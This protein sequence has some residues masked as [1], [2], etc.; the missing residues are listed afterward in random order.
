MK[1][2]NTTPRIEPGPL[3]AVIDGS[4]IYKVL[5]RDESEFVL[6]TLDGDADE[7]TMSRTE[8]DHGVRDGKLL[9]EE[10]YFTPSGSIAGRKSRFRVLGEYRNQIQ[11]QVLCDLRWA[12]K[13]KQSRDKTGSPSLSHNALTLWIE[14]EYPAMLVELRPILAS[15][16]TDG[17]AVSSAE[18]AKRTKKRK[19]RR[20]TTIDAPGATALRDALRKLEA[21]NWDVMVLVPGWEN[22]TEGGPRIDPEIRNAL[23][24]I[25]EGYKTEMKPSYSGLRRK[26]RGKLDV[27]NA[28]RQVPL[29]LPCLQTVI[30]VVR[31]TMP[32]VEAL[33]GRENIAAARQKLAMVGE[34]PKY[35][36][37]G[38]HVMMDCWQ[39]HLMSIYKECGRWSL[40]GPEEKD[41]IKPLR[42]WVAVL[43]DSA[44]GCIPGISFSISEKTDAVLGAF[45]MALMD[46]SGIARLL[47]CQQDWLEPFSFD[48]VETD[49]GP[50]FTTKDFWMPAAS[51]AGHVRKSAGDHPRLRGKIE[52]LFG[53]M[54][55]M[56]L[57]DF[58]GRTGSNVLDKGD[59]NPQARATM[60]VDA[61]CNSLIRWIVDIY[62]LS[63]P[64]AV[65]SQSPYRKFKR[66][67][68]ETGLK[69]A[70][71]K[72]LLRKSF[73]IEVERELG[74]W[75]IRHA[76]VMYYRSR[77]LE[78]FLQQHGPQTV[79]VRIDPLDIGQISVLLDKTWVTVGG[80]PELDG[81]GLHEWIS[82]NRELERRYLAEEALDWPT[83]A[84]AM[85]DME[86]ASEA[87]IAEAH[88][89]DLQ[90]TG[91][92]LGPLV[93]SLKLHVVYDNDPGAHR[94]VPSIGAGTMGRAFVPSGERPAVSKS[95]EP[96]APQT[97]SS[98]GKAAPKGL[99][100]LLDD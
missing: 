50:V 94:N 74:R 54:D 38:E 41:I 23:K 42:V 52:R 79:K 22:C 76:N 100:N 2:R 97:S 40:L 20:W 87:A 18:A 44:T 3:A 6:V 36:R 33:V 14:K 32:E 63:R 53:T 8:M 59:Y 57:P 1:L 5:V 84:R 64:A 15:L 71:T 13:L 7:R 88:L 35:T 73:G 28:G 21:N 69:P 60:A 72:E 85:R 17:Q 30:R 45:R 4:C 92:N 91:K 11:V 99:W 67:A 29:K 62:H 89:R 46:R 66:L 34:G 10:G 80:P 25:G 9:V 31:D 86:S 58:T 70:P 49:G 48:C 27:L 47:G 68:D 12:E 56:F 82:V 65:G 61:V 96:P 16:S 19:N 77:R 75:G 93:A 95:Y 43:Q 24:E 55:K 39:M 90:V 51:I 78:A 83:V 37:V 98:S 81:C 26:L